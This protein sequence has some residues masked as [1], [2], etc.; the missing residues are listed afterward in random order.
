MEDGL[1]LP[2]ELDLVQPPLA[3][4]ALK[5]VPSMAPPATGHWL[6]PACPS[7]YCGSP[8]FQAC[9]NREYVSWLSCFA[10]PADHMQEPAALCL[11]F[12]KV[13]GHSSWRR[14][15]D[16]EQSRA[17][18]KLVGMDHLIRIT[19]AFHT[20]LRSLSPKMHPPD[21]NP[22]APGIGSPELATLK[23]MVAWSHQKF[24]QMEGFSVLDHDFL[25]QT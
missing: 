14:R 9:R 7:T 8:S 16:G 24:L 4:L 18:P 6:P 15:A 13:N 22:K 3:W 17:A 20:P 25:Q 12:R 19:V 2:E 1:G 10:T 23:E 5:E 21:S 11:K